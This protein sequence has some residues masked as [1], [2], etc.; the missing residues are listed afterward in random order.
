[1]IIKFCNRTISIKKTVIQNLVQIRQI[2]LASS[3]FVKFKINN[4]K[5]HNRILHV[6]NA[7]GIKHVLYKKL[8]L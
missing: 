1:M 7:G 4:M 3:L 2:F 8:S 5:K 6:K